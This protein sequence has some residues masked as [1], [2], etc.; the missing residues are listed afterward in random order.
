MYNPC[1]ISSFYLYFTYN[2]GPLA[3]MTIYNY[4]FVA[5]ILCILYPFF[6][7]IFL[8]YLECS[9]LLHGD[10]NSHR[11]HRDISL[12]RMVGDFRLPP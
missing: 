9:N 11:K 2:F 8:R 4:S 6:H 1:H 10:T 12:K 5:S 3:D 7:V